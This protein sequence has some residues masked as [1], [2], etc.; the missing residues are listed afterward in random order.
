[1]PLIVISGQ[2]CSGKTSVALQ[3]QELLLSKGLK[4]GI[5]SEDSLLLDKNKSYLD[6]TSEKNTRGLLKS[7][8][9]RKLGNEEY[10]IMDSINNIKGY[11]YEIWCIAKAVGTR[12]CL[13]HVDTPVEVCR[14][15]NA[16]RR[17][18]DAYQQEIFEDLA[19]RFE[20]P[21]IKNRWDC[22]LYTYKYDSS[23]KEEVLQQVVETITG[24][25]GMKSIKNK[26]LAPNIATKTTQLS[27]TDTLGEIDRAAQEIVD[28]IAQQQNQSQGI[29]SQVI[30]FGQDLPQLRVSSTLSLLELRRHKRAFMKLA[31]QIVYT[32]LKDAQSAKRVFIEHLQHSIEQ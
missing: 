14:Q 31:T 23:D 13:V 10:L 15:W 11:R 29:G 24:S 8:V 21:D 17:E 22:P 3:L 5:L 1:M 9:E 18:E 6:V 20:T 19:G 25:S 32:K 12:Y 7:S 28:M 26:N 27:N 4:V 2:P 30:C 16:Q